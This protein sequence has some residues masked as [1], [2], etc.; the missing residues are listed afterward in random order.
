MP[1][2]VKDSVGSLASW[3]LES[4]RKALDESVWPD[5]GDPRLV[6][7]RNLTGK[8][9]LDRGAV[10]QA[11]ATSILYGLPLATLKTEKD[12]RTALTTAASNIYAPAGTPGSGLQ[13]VTSPN[14][15]DPNPIG[16][17]LS[18]LWD[19]LKDYIVPIAIIGGGLWYWSTRKGKQE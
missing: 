15:P 9:P 18:G 10:N 1:D 3:F 16:S 14:L 5:A 6:S 11:Q 4:W 19:S 7:I 8:D 2:P 12:R 17:L 13:T